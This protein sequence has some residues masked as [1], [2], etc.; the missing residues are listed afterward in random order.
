MDFL[1]GKIKPMYI[2]YLSAAFGS[3]ACQRKLA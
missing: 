2:Q 3:A 1:N